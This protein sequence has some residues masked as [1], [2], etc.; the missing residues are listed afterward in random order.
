M[1]AIFMVFHFSGLLFE[2]ADA[3]VLVGWLVGWLV[4]WLLGW[5]LGWLL[6]GWLFSVL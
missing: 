5:L 3:L 6:A 2:D 4:A 1:F